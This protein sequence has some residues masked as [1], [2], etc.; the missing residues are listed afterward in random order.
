MQIVYR[1]IFAFVLVFTRTLQA[2]E[3]DDNL[4]IQIFSPEANIQVRYAKI[5]PKHKYFPADLIFLPGKGGFL[6]EYQHVGK[7]LA[8]DGHRVWMLEWRGQGGSTRIPDRVH[9]DSFDQYVSDLHAF[10]NKNF[11]F[12]SV[13]IFALSMGGHVALRYAADHPEKIEYIATVAPLVK[14]KTPIPFQLSKNIANFMWLISYHKEF[15][16][17]QGPFNLEQACSILKDVCLVQ[18]GELNRYRDI[19]QK[20]KD[21]VGGGVTWGWVAAAMESSDKLLSKPINVPVLVFEST[22]DHLIDTSSYKALYEVIQKKL[23]YHRYDAPHDMFYGD[24]KLVADMIDNI[25]IFIELI[26]LS[27]AKL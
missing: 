4:D 21:K 7:K 8:H 9:I 5:E 17:G 1:I 25:R 6:E 18:E 3:R 20:Y 22:R 27:Q 13:G 16:L 15:A 14:M 2:A 23:I 10:I 19:M 24:S 26:A 12:S 11:K